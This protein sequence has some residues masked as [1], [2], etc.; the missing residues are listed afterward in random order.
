MVVGAEIGIVLEPRPQVVGVGRIDR[1]ERPAQEWYVER[2]LAVK[3]SNKVA[4]HSL[5]EAIL[6]RTARPSPA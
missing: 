3:V 5:A 4:D 2:V 1:R 6:A